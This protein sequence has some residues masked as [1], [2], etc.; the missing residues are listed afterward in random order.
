M[1]V[2]EEKELE[3]EE[4]EGAGEEQE[5]PEIRKSKRITRGKAK[6]ICPKN[7]KKKK[8]CLKLD[9]V[10]RKRKK[11]LDA[12]TVGISKAKANETQSDS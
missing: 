1:I 9:D 4:E 2:E 6:I 10:P 8:D 12:S 3:V 11:L 5:A 7:S